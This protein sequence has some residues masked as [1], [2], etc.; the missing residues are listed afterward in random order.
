MVPQPWPPLLSDSLRSART[1]TVALPGW[2]EG[3]TAVWTGSPG[4]RD[5]ELVVSGGGELGQAVLGFHEPQFS[6]FSN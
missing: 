3:G 6:Y 4:Q 1:L 2:V 5:G